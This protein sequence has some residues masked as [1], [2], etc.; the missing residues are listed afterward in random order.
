LRVA[1]N[2]LG[3]RLV[4]KLWIGLSAQSAKANVSEKTLQRARRIGAAL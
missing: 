4:A 1:A 3:A 2:C